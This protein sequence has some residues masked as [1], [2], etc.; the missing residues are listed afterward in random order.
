MAEAAEGSETVQPARSLT[1][2]YVTVGIV[3]TLFA[4]VAWGW[5]PAQ[6]RYWERR[7]LRAYQKPDLA[8]ADDAVE[9]LAEVGRPARAAFERLLAPNA[10][11]YRG[12]VV[13]MLGRRAN[14][15]ALPVL[16]RLARDDRDAGVRYMALAAAETITGKAFFSAEFVVRRGA[17]SEFAPGVEQARQQLL[18]W[19]DAEGRSRYGN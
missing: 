5:K 18:D 7:A 8:A 12:R 4:L 3:A 13:Q 1:G 2:F 17:Q 19:W 10:N 11:W 15:W 16:V 14:R 9:K 6:A